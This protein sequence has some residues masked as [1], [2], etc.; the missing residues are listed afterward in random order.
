MKT[1]TN[2]NQ[3]S[4]DYQSLLENNFLRELE[5]NHKES[6]QNGVKKSKRG[7]K[8]KSKGFYTT[9]QPRVT[10][11]I[12]NK[13][14][15]SFLDQPKPRHLKSCA[16]C[17]KHK[18]KCNYSETAPNP[19]SSC[20][21]RGLTCEL[22]IVI[23]LKRSNI[24]RNLT[25][26]VTD[27]Q[28]AVDKL[29]LRDSYLK[30]LCKEKS[31][32]VEGLTDF[33]D[34]HKTQIDPV[35]KEPSFSSLFPSQLDQ[36]LEGIITPPLSDNSIEFRDGS[37]SSSIKSDLTDDLVS[38][39]FSVGFHDSSDES[40]T[41][42]PPSEQMTPPNEDIERT[43]LA[44]MQ[45]FRIRNVCSYNMLS[46]DRFFGIFNQRMLPY[47]PI[48]GEIKSP[49]AVYNSS[50]LL[51]WTI[52]YVVSANS[53]I[54]S[55]FIKGEL[56]KKCWLET[57]HD[58]SIIQTI[59]ILASFPVSR[60]GNFR[61]SDNF[62]TYIFRQL[63]F[64][65]DF[66]SQIGLGRSTQF[67]G[68]FSRRTQ[69]YQLKDEYRY[70]I[71]SLLFILGNLYGFKLG[72]RWDFK[73][74]Y[75]IE[76]C[77]HT[78]SYIGRLLNIVL[79]QSRMM[80]QLISDSNFPS[81]TGYERPD[82]ARYLEA[83]IALCKT[84]LQKYKLKE[85]DINIL[86][87]ISMFELS[88]QLFVST[89]EG[90]CNNKRIFELCK[91]SYSLLSAINIS[92]APVYVQM[93]LELISLVL[94][95]ISLAPN[96]TITLDTKLLVSVFKSLAATNEFGDTRIIAN[97]LMEV[98][99]SFKLDSRAIRFG[100]FTS[101]KSQFIEGLLDDLKKTVN[102]Y[103]YGKGNLRKLKSFIR[104]KK[105]NFSKY[106]DNIEKFNRD[107]D[108]IGLYSNVLLDSDM[109]KTSQVKDEK[110]WNSNCLTDER[111]NFLDKNS[112]MNDGV[113]M[114]NSEDYIQI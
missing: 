69:G 65:K 107:V 67:S 88:I 70:N 8:R 29:L 66:S 60:V 87:L 73:V 105:L 111:S 58:I 77:R 54:E 5:K 45:M 47:V 51:F 4:G 83:S 50:R 31:I 95:K 106:R 56:I 20:A 98:Q 78:K 27:L 38:G 85:T 7:R 63:E 102:D 59:I 81:D 23:P 109:T 104:S 32:E 94:M 15:P 13:N 92:R 30:N 16:R 71:W 64:A 24:I 19:C 68:E 37:V 93:D 76:S 48:I 41:T 80:D 36:K 100:D 82:K 11:R 108:L 114:I 35:K 25:T 72:M 53:R 34:I 97:L 49:L 90:A 62:D 9:N 33:K 110:Q 10:T 91:D 42:A 14:P 79:L 28:S 103:S 12:V 86:V 6:N 89:D 17:R 3:Y 84:E 96:T 57:P 2:P 46:I 55:D 22:E 52:V 21:S 18:T 61:D 44:Q 101:F 74:D 113:S 43:K 26:D 75:I 99:S 40:T 39:S 1:L 112:L